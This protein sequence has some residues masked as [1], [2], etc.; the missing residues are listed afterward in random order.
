MDLAFTRCRACI[1]RCGSRGPCTT[2]CG[3]CIARCGNLHYTMWSLHCKMWELALQDVELTLLQDLTPNTQKRQELGMPPKPL[4]ISSTTLFTWEVSCPPPA[5]AMPL[6]L[7]LLSSIDP[8]CK[9]SFL[10]K[11]RLHIQQTFH[12]YTSVLRASDIAIPTK[13]LLLLHSCDFAERR[14]RNS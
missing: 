4:S 7:L 5:A 1:A 6:L 9:G 8:G 3:A 10:Q 12:T 13:L 2:R 14:L 11:E